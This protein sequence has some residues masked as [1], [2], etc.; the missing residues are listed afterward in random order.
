MSQ[1]R[2]NGKAGKPGRSNKNGGRAR[3][4]LPIVRATRA[5]AT[6]APRARLDGGAGGPSAAQAPFEL[7]QTLQQISKWLEGFG[8]TE[9]DGRQF[10]EQPWRRRPT[11]LVDRARPAVEKHR[12]EPAR[13]R[14][15]GAELDELDRGRVEQILRLG[16]PRRDLDVAQQ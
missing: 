5:P 9:V 16:H 12:S 13:G 11:R 14:G 15:Q 1:S 10:Q 2:R 8:L 6:R 4:R 3:R 7:F